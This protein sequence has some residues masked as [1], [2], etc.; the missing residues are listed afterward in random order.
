M[1]L[2]RILSPQYMLLRNMVVR[3][4]QRGIDG[5]HAFLRHMK[6]APLDFPERCQ[7]RNV[8]ACSSVKSRSLRGCCKV[9]RLDSAGPR[10][11]GIGA[12]AFVI[13]GRGSKDDLA[14]SC[15]HSMAAFAIQLDWALGIDNNIRQTHNNVCAGI[16]SSSKG[17]VPAPRRR[18]ADAT[19]RWSHDCRLFTSSQTALQRSCTYSMYE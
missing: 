7:D 17:R 5:A 8:V 4:R 1:G 19:A 18:H 16:K 9:P 12:T 6:A 15:I 3:K 11:A 2:Q 14:L 10:T 13:C